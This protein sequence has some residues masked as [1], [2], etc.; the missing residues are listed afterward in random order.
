MFWAK[1]GEELQENVDHGEILPNHDGTFQM[2]VDLNLTSVKH[3]DWKQY[4][5]VFQLYGVTEDFKHTLDRE[6]IKTNWGKTVIIGLKE[7]WMC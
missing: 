2:S 7:E 4:D 5:C 6:L 1:D 3:E